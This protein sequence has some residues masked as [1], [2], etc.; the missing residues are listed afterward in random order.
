MERALDR[1]P[2]EEHQAFLEGAVL[3]CAYNRDMKA[4]NIAKVRANDTPIAL[5]NALSYPGKE[6][7]RIQADRLSGLPKNIILSRGSTFRLTS[8]LWTA[9][10]LTNGAEGIVHSI[11]YAPNT[12]P[13]KDLPLAIIGIF[14]DYQGPSFLPGVAKSVP[15]CPLRRTWISNGVECT[16]IMLPVILGYA[17]S[18]HKLQGA[19]LDK[20]ILNPGTKEFALGLLLVGASRVKTFQGLAFSPYPNFDRFDQIRRSAT[21]KLRMKEEA[22]LKEL[23]QTTIQKLQAEGEELW[24]VVSQE[25]VANLQGPLAEAIIE[26]QENR[27]SH[28]GLINL[29]NSCYAN[30]V[31]QCLLNISQLKD[32]VTGEEV[33]TNPESETRGEIAN[34]IRNLFKKM[35]NGEPGPFRPA[36]FMEMVKNFRPQFDGHTQEDAY[37]FLNFLITALEDDLNEVRGSQ[38][39]IKSFPQLD[40]STAADMAWMYVMDRSKS[41]IQDNFCGQYKTWIECPCGFASVPVYEAFSALILPLVDTAQ[42]LKDCVVSFLEPEEVELTCEG[43]QSRTR[44]LKRTELIR[45]PRVLV[46]MVA[47]FGYDYS[48]RRWKDQRQLDYDLEEMDFGQHVKGC[49]GGKNSFQRYSLSGLI[50]HVGQGI[51]AGHYIAYCK[52]QEWRVFDD[53][54]VTP[55]SVTASKAQGYIF[56]YT[57]D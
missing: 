56:F 42:S 23:E 39:V 46:L 20:V 1:L 12:K 47:R 57:A 43:C 54:R 45:L 28:Q 55:G 31:I 36:E 16:R 2:D 34:A 13:P 30:S 8:N 41:V 49:N 33:N 9:A 50:E 53:A 27:T 29:G 44:S 6:A 4:H 14:K 51:G 37:E 15:I 38:R 3:A 7:K 22:R 48:G 32:H 35:S 11:I 19:T 10:G 21:L 17:L 52:D 40:S 25:E 26:E 18:I 24:Q 5:I